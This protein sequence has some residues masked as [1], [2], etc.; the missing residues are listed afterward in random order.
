MPRRAD[1]SKMSVKAFRKSLDSYTPR[2][3]GG[4]PHR[5]GTFNVS[6]DGH[7]GHEY[8]GVGTHNPTTGRI[9]FDDTTPSGKHSH[10]V[11][12][13]ATGQ[14]TVHRPEG[15]QSTR[16]KSDRRS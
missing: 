15:G 6:G 11:H 7:S 3:G 14:V 2:S 5:A 12:N 8:H 4:S 9:D 16:G 10:T 1:G 13:T